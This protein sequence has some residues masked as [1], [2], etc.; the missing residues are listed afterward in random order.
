M[1]LVGAGIA[2]N[3]G[4]YLLLAAPIIPEYAYERV[5]GV[6]LQAAALRT[7]CRGR[8]VQCCVSSPIAQLGPVPVLIGTAVITVGWI[9]FVVR[10]LGPNRT[11]TV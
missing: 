2:W 4:A 11:Q 1:L 5:R 7:G 10:Q 6:W 3:V 9:T 8:T